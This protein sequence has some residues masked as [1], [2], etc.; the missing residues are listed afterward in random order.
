MRVYPDEMAC[1]SRYNEICARSCTKNNMMRRNNLPLRKQIGL[2][3]CSNECYVF[4]IGHPE[5][6]LRQI[7]GL[8]GRAWFW[9]GGRIRFFLIVSVRFQTFD[10]QPARNPAAPAPIVPAAKPPIAQEVE[11]W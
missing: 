2:F 1:F 7:C 11:T 9:R 3:I 8:T 4:K 6:L 10:G 5:A